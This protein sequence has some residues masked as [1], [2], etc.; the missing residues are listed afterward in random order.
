MVLSSSI[1]LIKAGGIPTIFHN[2]ST[3]VLI[4]FLEPIVRLDPPQLIGRLGL[5]I[6]KPVNVGGAQLGRF[7][8]WLVS[9]FDVAAVGYLVESAS[10]M[11]P[12]LSSL[13]WER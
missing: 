8:G 1:I 6:Q 7:V 10:V 5:I 4:F 2:H 3:S 13:G 11:R 12:R 9:T